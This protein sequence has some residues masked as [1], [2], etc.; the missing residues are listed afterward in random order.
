MTHHAKHIFAFAAALI[1]AA[2]T[3]AE[4]V[5]VPAT[6]PGAAPAALAA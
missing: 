1:V 4:I 5:A 2:A 6:Q 3:F